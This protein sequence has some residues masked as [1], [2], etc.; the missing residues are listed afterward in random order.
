LIAHAIA[1]AIANATSN[2][3]SDQWM[4]TG[5]G[6]I[7]NARAPAA[8]NVGE[9]LLYRIADRDAVLSDKAHVT[10]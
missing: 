4:R 6:A 1:H 8:T 10:A 3:G 7:S 2:A 9:T 5:E